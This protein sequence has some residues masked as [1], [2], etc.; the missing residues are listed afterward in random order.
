MCQRLLRPAPRLG[1]VSLRSLPIVPEWEQS[2]PQP[3][4]VE[5]GLNR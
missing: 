3:E 4:W 5:A 1:K 2:Q